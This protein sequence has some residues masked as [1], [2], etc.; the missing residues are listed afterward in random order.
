MNWPKLKYLLPSVRRQA[1]RDMREELEALNDLAETKGELGNLTLAAEDAR[2]TWG[3]TWLTSLAAD[4][5]YGL[6]TL[7]R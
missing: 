3:W 2:N 4:V 5:R 6:R 1:D 7:L